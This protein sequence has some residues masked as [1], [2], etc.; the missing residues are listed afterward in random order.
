MNDNLKFTKRLV[1]WPPS[2]VRRLTPTKQKVPKRSGIN[3]EATGPNRLRHD[4]RHPG[5]KKEITNALRAARCQRRSALGA[6]TSTKGEGRRL[7][8]G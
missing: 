6:R 5:G 1:A 3:S 4:L 7:E 2:S 8:L